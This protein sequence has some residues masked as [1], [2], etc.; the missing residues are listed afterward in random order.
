MPV[1]P[2][3][4]KSWLAQYSN[5]LHIW[6][7]KGSAHDDAQDAVQDAAVR[8]LVNGDGT[9]KDPRAYLSRSAANGMAGRH[10]HRKVLDMLPLHALA[11]HDHPVTDSAESSARTQELHDALWLALSELPLSC[12]Q[13]FIL[14]RLE[15]WTHTEIAEDMGI[16]RSMVEKH[17][18]RALRHL[19]ERLQ[20]YA[21]Y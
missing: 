2:P 12:R 6:R 21:P 19:H 5:L 10:R 9:I 11:D 18:T 16:S 13:T 3:P 8:I 15:G 1:R 14:H 17:M 20:H 7:R 4:K